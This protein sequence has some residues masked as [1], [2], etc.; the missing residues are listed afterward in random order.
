MNKRIIAFVLI[1]LTAGSMQL[2]DARGRGGGGGGRGMRGGGF[3]GGGFKGGGMRMGGMRGGGM[4]MGGARMGGVRMGGAR[5]GAG[6]GFAGR[7]AVAGAR[8]FKRPAL[9]PSRRPGMVRPIAPGMRPGIGRP[10]M[11]PGIGRPGMRPGM[12]LGIGRPGMRPGMRPGIGRP[13]R[14]GIGRPGRP[15]GIGKPGRPGARPGMAARGR[16]ARAAQINRIRN[17]NNS[18]VNQLRARGRFN[19]VA[20]FRGRGFHRGFFNFINPFWWSR[21]SWWPFGFAPFAWVPGFGLSWDYP[22]DWYDGPVAPIVERTRIIERIDNGEFAQAIAALQDEIA[23]LQDM[24]ATAPDPRAVSQE[25]DYAQD[26]VAQ[27][28]AYQQ[29]NDIAQQ[30]AGPEEG[31]YDVDM[32]AGIESVGEPAAIEAY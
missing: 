28:Q 4:R 18:R 13:G 16:G 19:R 17:I 12:R 31:S 29:A 11:R 24:L 20:G 10:G 14:P 5:M 32:S 7:G 27:V 21:F 30:Y 1:C 23:R 25:I 6:R 3:R 15:G 22:D 9:A 2:M 26:L 8:G